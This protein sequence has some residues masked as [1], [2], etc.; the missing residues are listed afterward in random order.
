MRIERILVVGI[1]TLLVM[2]GCK[3]KKEEK[4]AAPKVMA[5]PVSSLIK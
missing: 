3:G 5:N 4:P 1:L 2:T